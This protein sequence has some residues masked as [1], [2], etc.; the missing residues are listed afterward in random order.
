MSEVEED[1]AKVFKGLGLDVE[2]APEFSGT[3]RRR[4]LAAFEQAG[5]KPQRGRSWAV[6]AFRNRIARVG[7]AAS[8]LAA[9]GVGV[10]LGAGVAKASVSFPNVIV[11]VR[12]A[13]SL[14]YTL[15]IALPDGRPDEFRVMMDRAGRYRQTDDSGK[16]FI[17]D[18]RMGKRLMLSPRTKVAML[19][20]WEPIQESDGGFERVSRLRNVHADQGVFEAEGK[21][22][23]IACCVFRVETESQTV[24]IWVDRRTELPV[25]MEIFERSPDTAKGGEPKP[26]AVISRMAW[27]VDLPDSLFSLAPPPGYVWED[28]YYEVVTEADLTALLRLCAEQSGR[29]VFP[30]ACDDAAIYAAL[31]PLY[32]ESGSFIMPGEGA[33]VAVSEA[34][35]SEIKQLVHKGLAFIRRQQAGKTWGYRGGGVRLGDAASLVCWWRPEGSDKCRAV[36]GD[37]SIRDISGTEAPASLPTTGSVR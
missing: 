20:E 3:L 36:Y 34:P 27:N 25:R 10:W 28:E 17:A 21:L 14:S 35:P 26:I 2:P 16:V 18:Y 30:G 33:A 31:R 5:R 11:R 22:D 15:T 29:G 7:V 13:K 9:V 8:V 24:R 19:R 1:I 32:P 6:A 12:K 4:V 23:G 37:L